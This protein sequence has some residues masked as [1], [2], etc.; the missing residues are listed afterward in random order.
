M[1]FFCNMQKHTHVS[2]D[3]CCMGR[4]LRQVDAGG[5]LG[6]L[7]K[8]HCKY[9]QGRLYSWDIRTGKPQSPRAVHAHTDRKP[10]QAMGLCAQACAPPPIWLQCFSPLDHVRPPRGAAAVSALRRRAG[11]CCRRGACGGRT[12][13]APPGAGSRRGAQAGREAPHGRLRLDRQRAGDLVHAQAML[14]RGRR[15]RQATLRQPRRRLLRDISKR[16]HT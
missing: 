11:P 12:S 1:Y 6:A 2:H 4:S 13:R 3:T 10:V 16:L 8:G 14:Q 9:S 5:E 15:G 7:H